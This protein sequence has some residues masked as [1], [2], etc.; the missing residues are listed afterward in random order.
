[1]RLLALDIDH[2]LTGKG[3]LVTQANQEAVAWAKDRGVRVTL[4]TGRRYAGSAARHAEALGITGPLG[5]HY[6]RRVV[7][8]PSGAILT[9][10][11]MPIDAA[12]HL[13]GVALS[14]AGAIVSGF[15]DDEL[16]FQKLPPALF[17]AGFAQFGEGDL[18]E[19]MA[20]RPG[21]I[22]SLN[23]SASP[24]AETGAGT[25]DGGAGETTSSAGAR[26]KREGPSVVEAIVTAAEGRYPDLIQLYFVP[27]GE[28]ERGLVTAIS[29]VA[30]KGTALLEIA[31][32]AGINPADTVAMG[33]SE[34]DIPMLRAA[35]VGVAMPWSP[36]KVRR[37]ADLV[38]EGDPE[39]AVARTIRALAG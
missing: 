13:V 30:D 23:V 33:D 32:R 6:G 37:A 38:A 7:D 15:F 26:G 1:M 18:Q 2:T 28:I 19:M 4:I 34:A 35:G 27:W 5:C 9:N 36:E 39:D 8:H 22:M 29:A 16:V 14:H 20:A 25:G 17:T 21:A 31:R 12:R 24:D 3:H 10:H 11:P